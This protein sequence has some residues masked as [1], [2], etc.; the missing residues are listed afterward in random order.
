MASF[1]ITPVGQG[2]GHQLIIIT[3]WEKLKFPIFPLLTTK[4]GMT[5]CYCWV[6][7]GI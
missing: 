6:R 5:P 4:E 7:M 2:T 1:D 3:C